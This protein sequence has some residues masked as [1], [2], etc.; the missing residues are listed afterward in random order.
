[1][2]SV[3]VFRKSLGFT[4]IIGLLLCG[5]VWKSAAHET[6]Y[7][8]IVDE[9]MVQPAPVMVIGQAGP[10]TIAD[11][12]ILLPGPG[13]T[14]E[15]FPVTVGDTRVSIPAQKIS[16]VPFIPLPSSSSYII[17]GSLPPPGQTLEALLPAMTI[18]LPRPVPEKTVTMT[19]VLPEPLRLKAKL[20]PF[21][22]HVF[23]PFG[24][25]P[26][27][28]QNVPTV[29]VEFDLF[30]II[31]LNLKIKGHNVLWDIDI[32]ANYKTLNARYT[33]QDDSW[34]SSF[35][36]NDIRIDVPAGDLQNSY[37][38]Y[39]QKI[40]K[41]QLTKHKFAL[42]DGG[43]WLP[44]KMSGNLV[45]HVELMSIPPK[46]QTASDS[47]IFNFTMNSDRISLSVDYGDFA[48]T[49]L[50]GGQIFQNLK[51]EIPISNLEN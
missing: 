33:G 42:F 39:F 43:D 50:P 21:I 23:S 41:A 30:P 37:P 13:F 2:K 19:A 35:S 26:G 29:P 32:S 49:S 3:Y 14:L 20:N 12:L 17:Q 7:A 34:S 4:F 18:T 16:F 27:F 44:G 11:T 8:R 40:I 5:V 6:H 38:V 36:V 25:G 46:Q 45:W 28:I 31:T 10:V 48:T 47:V 51:L 15:S 22:L 1:M 24:Y 9:F